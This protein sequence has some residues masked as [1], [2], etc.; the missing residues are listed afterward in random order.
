MSLFDHFRKEEHPF[1][2]RAL[3]MLLLVEQR[4]TMRLTD[5]LDP[6]QF[7]IFQSLT[8]QVA[9]VRVDGRGGYDGAERVRALLY[10]GYIVPEQDDFKLVLVQIKGDQ[11]FV[12]LS[13]RDVLGA[14]LHIGL[15]REKFGDILMDGQG[16]QVIVAQEVFEYVRMQ[17]TQIHRIP[18]ELVSVGW[19]QLRIPAEQRAEK[20]FTVSSPRLDA[21]V[22][23][24][25]RLSR[26]KALLP[27]RAGR[28]KV[29]WKVVDDP[30][31]MLAPGDVVSLT[32]FGRFE[33]YE[34]APT[35]RSGRIRI[36]VGEYM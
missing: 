2:E 36:I 21:V 16:C 29:N 7:S 31:Y 4:Q 20:N 11:R 14:L 26:S 28:A 25:Y 8:S 24:V 9:D 33:V 32:G 34:M 22:G 19:D 23:E 30:A 6:R 1:V 15:K 5:F 3:E 18:V 12:Q 27:I 35:A 17:V 13:H 10:P